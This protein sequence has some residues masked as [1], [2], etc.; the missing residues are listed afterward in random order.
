[1]AIEFAGA[2]ASSSTGTSITAGSAGVKG[3]YV[4][5]VSSTARESDL[6]TVT[7]SAVTGAATRST[8]V[9]IATGAAA[10]ETDLFEFIVP[11][12]TLAGTNV[13][14]TIPFNIAA[15]TRV[16]AAATSSLASSVVDVQVALSDDDSWGTSSQ[17]SLIGESSQKGTA[18]DPGGTAN[19]K[20]SWTEL[21]SS[22]PHDIDYMLVLIAWNANSAISPA[23]NFLVDIGTGAAA[24][25]T[26]LVENIP[27]Y[28][29]VFEMRKTVYPIYAPISS[30]TRIAARAQCS[31]TDATDRICDVSILGCN[32]TAPSGGGGGATQHAYASIG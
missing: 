20:G 7:A 6:L 26:V 15:S 17:A 8:K 9:H 19:T 1:M 11:H 25:E 16:S 5:L 2:D 29:D 31:G 21:T 28:H 30:G 4:E 32:L 18:I 3:S 12:G 14:F 22:A 23:L 10:S 27:K 13:S 24:S